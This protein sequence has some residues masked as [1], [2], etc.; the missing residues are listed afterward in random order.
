MKLNSIS[1]VGYLS[2]PRKSFM[3]SRVCASSSFEKSCVP[4]LRGGIIQLS[5]RAGS[6]DWALNLS[7]MLS[8]WFL[9]T[10]SMS[11]S[12]VDVIKAYCCCSNR[13]SANASCGTV[14]ARTAVNALIISARSFGLLTAA[15]PSICGA[16]IA[17]MFSFS[18]AS[19][20]V[21]YTHLTLPTKA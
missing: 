9:T 16:T 4:K 12:D 6:Y 15:A 17:S 19:A 5:S 11:G 20:T 10:S 13:L 1:T 21:S 2:E 18:L 7:T 8:S 14:C 3:K